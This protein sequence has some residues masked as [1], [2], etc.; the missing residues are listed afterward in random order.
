MKRVVQSIRE[1]VNMPIIVSSNLKGFQ[2]SGFVR[3]TVGTTK[4]KEKEKH[5]VITLEQLET[6]HVCM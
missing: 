6:S 1:Q 2:M 5:D 3:P 4:I